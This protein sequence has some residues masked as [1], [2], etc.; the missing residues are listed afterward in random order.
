MSV[1]IRDQS[2]SQPLA[3]GGPEF[4]FP[5]DSQGS[6]GALIMQRYKQEKAAFISDMIAGT[7]RPGRQYH[8]TYPTAQVCETSTPRETETGLY[9]FTRTWAV[10]PSAPVQDA[11]DYAFAYPAFSGTYTGSAGNV[12]ALTVAAGSTVAQ[13]NFTLTSTVASVAQGDYIYVYIHYTYYP[14]AYT[15]S[16]HNSVISGW[17]QVTAKSGSDYTISAYGFADSINSVVSGTVYKGVPGRGAPKNM[18]VVSLLRSS[19]IVT[20]VPEE[21]VLPQRFF[22][23]IASTGVEATSLTTLTVPTAAQYVAMMQSQS[24]L[25]VESKLKRWRGNIWQL[26]TRTVPAL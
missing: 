10:V 12:S 1:V 2:F 24:E 19:Y 8:P 25:V 15:A 13:R 3:V 11:E 14:A 4:E 21:I 6:D 22:P 9:E 23:V 18:I 17:Y 20:D 5:F 26:T 7:Y 16:L